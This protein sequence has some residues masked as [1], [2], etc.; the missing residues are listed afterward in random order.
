M[1]TNVLPLSETSVSLKWEVKAK[2]SEQLILTRYVVQISEDNFQ[3][4]VRE[5][6]G[7]YSS[8]NKQFK[9]FLIKN[10][11]FLFKIKAQYHEFVSGKY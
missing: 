7:K 10:I 9:D 6:P 11:T 8:V 4:D 1:I 3:F 2:K 5:W